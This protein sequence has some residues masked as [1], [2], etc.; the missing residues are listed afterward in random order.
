MYVVECMLFAVYASFIDCGNQNACE[1]DYWML[2]V[3]SFFQAIH[4]DSFVP[5]LD[6]L[7]NNEAD[8]IVC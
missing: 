8:I 4:A 5:D 3:L 6:E 2:S 1:R 7:S